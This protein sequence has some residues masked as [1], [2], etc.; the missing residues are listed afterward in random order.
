MANAQLHKAIKHPP[1]FTHITISQNTL[2]SFNCPQLLWYFGGWGK[3]WKFMFPIMFPPSCYQVLKVF[4][5]SS[6]C[7]TIMFPM[8]P[9]LCL[10]RSKCFPHKMFPKPITLGHTINSR[11]QFLKFSLWPYSQIWLNPLCCRWY[12]AHPPHKKVWK[13]H[14]VGKDIVFGFIIEYIVA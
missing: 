6:Q 5:S 7:N 8:L 3:V 9:Q 4:T 11:I 13:K 1:P 2:N 10:T 14:L 12:P